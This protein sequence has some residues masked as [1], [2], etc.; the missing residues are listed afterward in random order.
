MTFLALNTNT[1]FLIMEKSSLECQEMAAASEYDDAVAAVSSYLQQEGAD[2][3][4]TTYA[5]L[6]AEQ[7]KYDELKN[8]IESQL[9]VLNAEIEGYQKAVEANI[10]SEC[11][12]NIS[13]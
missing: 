6:V 10:K 12:L 5:Q 9:K 1:C 11:K 13:G 2:T 7:Q 8:S 3:T 4:S